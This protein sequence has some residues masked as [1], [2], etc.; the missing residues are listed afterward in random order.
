MQIH[1]LNLRNNFCSAVAVNVVVLGFFSSLV[2]LVSTVINIEPIS[3]E[4]RKQSPQTDMATHKPSQTDAIHY[5][6]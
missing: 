4:S 6:M 1:A 2:M 5:S 3:A